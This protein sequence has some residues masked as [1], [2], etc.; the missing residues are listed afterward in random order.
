MVLNFHFIQVFG[1]MFLH[2]QTPLWPLSNKDKHTPYYPIAKTFLTIPST[3][4]QTVVRQ[5]Q[6]ENPVTETVRQNLYD[7]IIKN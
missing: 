4:N 5:L 2:Q 6:I 1:Q 3:T 7:K